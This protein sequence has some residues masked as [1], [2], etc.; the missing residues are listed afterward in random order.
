MS[1]YYLNS[2]YNASKESKNLFTIKI[3]ILPKT[4]KLT[5]KNGET[6]DSF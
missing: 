1:V 2:F 4:K 5:E 3:V 6:M